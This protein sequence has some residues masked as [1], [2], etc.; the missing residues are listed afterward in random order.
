M[1]QLNSVTI[2]SIL[3][4]ILAFAIDKY[5]FNEEELNNSIMLGVSTTIGIYGGDLLSS[6]IPDNL[7]IPFINGK[8]IEGDILEIVG[9]TSV[10]YGVNSIIN[11]PIPIGI[12]TEKLGTIILSD[13]IATYSTEFLLGQVLSFTN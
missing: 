3:G 12:M 10:T 5:V 2:K 9:A 1:S 8:K 11:K 7:K 4:G 6:T 13:V